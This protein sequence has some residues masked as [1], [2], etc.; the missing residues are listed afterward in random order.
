MSRAANGITSWTSKWELM[1]VQVCASGVKTGPFI[2][3][4]VG[5]GGV[6]WGGVGDVNI[7]DNTLSFFL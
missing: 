6:G 4:G 2:W 5:W 1:E 7:G 3:G